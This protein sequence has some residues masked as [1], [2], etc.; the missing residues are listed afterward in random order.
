M[1]GTEL[2]KSIQT[3]AGQSNSS[4]ILPSPFNRRVSSSSSISLS[5]P[6]SGI[7]WYSTDSESEIKISKPIDG[8]TGVSELTGTYHLMLTTIHSAQFIQFRPPHTT[9]WMNNYSVCQARP[10]A[11]PRPQP[12][13]RLSKQHP[14]RSFLV[15]GKIYLSLQNAEYSLRLM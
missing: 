13:H 14:D 6:R 5:S 8:A 15:L 12:L 7:S 10:T 11:T 4:R 2:D 1:L 9:S 3:A